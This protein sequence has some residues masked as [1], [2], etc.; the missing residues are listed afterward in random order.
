MYRAALAGDD[1]SLATVAV[2]EHDG[3]VA[4]IG[5][6]GI[7]EQRELED[8]R[9]YR[10]DAA[11]FG[12]IS[13]VVTGCTIFIISGFGSRFGFGVTACSQQCQNLPA[14]PAWVDICTDSGHDARHGVGRE[15]AY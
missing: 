6:R 8:G 9:A 10:F 11:A 15:A 12:C 7:A 2:G 3:H 4:H 1:P 13:P 14:D 5:G